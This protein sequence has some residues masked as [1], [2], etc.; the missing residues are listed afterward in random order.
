MHSVLVGIRDQFEYRGVDGKILIKW[1]FEKWF[2]TAW[3]GSTWLRDRWRTL[4][5]AVINFVSIKCGKFLEQLR[6]C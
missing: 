5:N 3:I 2:R 1:I 6:N 4:V